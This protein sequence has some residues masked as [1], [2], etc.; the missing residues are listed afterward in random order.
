MSD[1]FVCDCF[2]IWLFLVHCFWD[3]VALSGPMGSKSLSFHPLQNRNLSWAMVLRWF[4]NIQEFLVTFSILQGG[5]STKYKS[6]Q[7]PS[8]LFWAFSRLGRG[9][10]FFNLFCRQQFFSGFL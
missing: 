1:D 6:E 5:F 9:N 10:F 7:A 3:F 8:S 4:K 2:V